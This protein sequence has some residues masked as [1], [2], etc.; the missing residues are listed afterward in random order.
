MTLRY[1]GKGGSNAWDGLSWDTRKLTLNGAEDTPVVAGDTVY[2]G[3]GVYR[4]TL[5]CDVNGSSGQPITYVADVTGENTDGVGGRVRLTGSNDDDTVF[6]TRDSM[7]EIYNRSYRTCR[8]FYFDKVNRLGVHGG[9]IRCGISA[10]SYNNI[11]IEDCVFGGSSMPYAN[12]WQAAIFLSAEGTAS[13]IT[14]R[15]CL[16]LGGCDYFV[17]TGNG[18]ADQEF[19]SSVIENCVVVGTKEYGIYLDETY[20][21][22]IRHCTFIGLTYAITSANITS[23]NQNYVYDCLFHECLYGMREVSAANTITENYNT[24]SSVSVSIDEGA[25]TITSY[26]LNQPPMLYQGIRFPYERF[27]V[28]DWFDEVYEPDTSGFTEDMFGLA[29]PAK[30]VRGG[31]QIKV[32]ERSADVYRSP[33]SALRLNDASKQVMFVPIEGGGK[34]RVTVY[35]L[36]K[37]NY[38]GTSPQLTVTVPSLA[39]STVTDTGSAGVWN[40]LSTVI[41]AGNNDRFMQIQVISNNAALSGNYMVYFDDL[42]IRGIAAKIPTMK[43]ATNELLFYGFDLEDIVD[44]W[45]AVGVPIPGVGPVGAVGPFPTFFRV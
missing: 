30:S 21:F 38:S 7:I 29:R 23:P 11:I 20:G 35:V 45:I 19:T 37:E 12:P 33:P 13:N 41:T 34:Y 1:V 25:Q 39:A 4:E 6:G 31:V 26:I 3:A 8:G 16:C 43:W 9:Y 40:R 27:N 17:K 28:T 10:G 32:A 36:R 44:P 15:N 2:V 22:T 42:G 18:A 24:L 14:I 5:Y